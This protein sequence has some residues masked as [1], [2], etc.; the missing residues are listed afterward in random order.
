[1]TVSFHQVAR[2]GGV[3][4]MSHWKANDTQ[5]NLTK[6]LILR[7]ILAE[8]CRF[9]LHIF[10]R[11]LFFSPRIDAQAAPA[12]LLVHW[13]VGTGRLKAAAKP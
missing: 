13:M 11:G 6:Y 2:D 5:A 4:R 12:Q 8:S 10:R 1:M 7:F 3:L 9:I